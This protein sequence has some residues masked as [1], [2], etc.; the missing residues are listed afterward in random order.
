M[1]DSSLISQGSTNSDR[2]DHAI[3]SGGQQGQGL[4]SRGSKQKKTD[5]G[6]E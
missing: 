3:G 6:A 5:K 4:G 2:P 1:G